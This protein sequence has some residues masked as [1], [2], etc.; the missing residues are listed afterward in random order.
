MVAPTL[1]IDLRSLAS[2]L[3]ACSSAA[4]S[5]RATRVVHASQDAVLSQVLI[6]RRRHSLFLLTMARATS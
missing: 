5:G 1:S 6:P 3:P 2:E 4:P